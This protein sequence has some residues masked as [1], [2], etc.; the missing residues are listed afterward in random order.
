MS[1]YKYA[2]AAIEQAATAGAADGCER[3][4]MLLA[5]IVSCVAE[6]RS[7]AGSEATKAALQ[8]ELGELQGGVD[9]QFIRSR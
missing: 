4:E 9:T 5:L 7:E 1:K 3:Q 2:K 6:Y 8:Y